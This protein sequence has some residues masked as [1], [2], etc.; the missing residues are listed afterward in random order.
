MELT[1]PNLGIVAPGGG[2]RGAFVCGA[3]EALIDQY[4]LTAPKAVLGCSG[5]AA[6][7][8]YYAANQSE[9][10]YEAYKYLCLNKLID[11]KRIFTNNKIKFSNLFNFTLLR[12]T[13]AQEYPIN[14]QNIIQNPTT[15]HIALTEY[16]T[17]K[18]I[19]LSNWTN[20]P[21]VDALLASKSIPVVNDGKIKVNDTY[22]TDG[23][24]ACPLD[25]NIAYLK[26]LG[27]QKI[28]V[29]DCGSK[30][31]FARRLLLKVHSH[32]E[33]I[34]RLLGNTIREYCDSTLQFY[35]EPDVFYINPMKPLPA[36]T[37]S[38]SW[39]KVRSTMDIGSDS[40]ICNPYLK[41][42]L[43]K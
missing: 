33:R 34:P 7:F 35:D 40:I 14:I 9:V 39:D 38:T 27:I 23:E 32:R 42:F 28:L 19:Y 6:P 36:G 31:T 21:L 4:N 24:L 43:N 11:L 8:A 41:E 5:S 13:F 26:S 20:T 1:H 3:L 15:L 30:L 2:L 10:G 16:E 12:Q 37:F 25:K 17:G 18:P 29:L 22:F